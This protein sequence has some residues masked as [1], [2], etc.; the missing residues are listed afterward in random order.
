MNEASRPRLAAKARLRYDRQRDTLV[1]LWPER[2][3][4]LNQSAGDVLRRCHGQETLSSIVNALSSQH[5]ETHRR[6]IE[7]D[8]YGLI[9]EL[10]RRG[11]L[12]LE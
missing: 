4:V 5:P 2:G 6:V 7:Q 10:S 3:L 12:T 1:L 8:V 9:R 11:L